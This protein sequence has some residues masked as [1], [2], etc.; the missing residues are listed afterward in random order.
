MTAR[1]DFGDPLDPQ[2]DPLLNYIGSVM[3]GKLA[4]DIGRDLYGA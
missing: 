4:Q 1:D 2:D 3:H